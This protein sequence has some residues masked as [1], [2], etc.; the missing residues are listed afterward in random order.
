M[1]NKQHSFD[2]VDEDALI[3]N[4]TSLIAILQLRAELQTHRTAYTFLENGEHPT[5]SL[6]YGELDLQARQ[7]AAQL[8]ALGLQGER[9]ILLYPPDLDY[10]VA[11]FACLYA[12]TIAVPAYPPTNG[13]HM[14]RLQAIIDDSRAAVILS[15]QSV[16][17]AV[18]QFAG[19]GVGLLDKR[20]L[21]TDNL[22]AVDSSGWRLPTLH[23]HDP[24]FLQYTSGSTGN[25]K[26]VMI[27]HGNLMAN[28]RLIKRRF[29]HNSDST[30]VGWLPLYHDMGLIGNVMQPLYCGASAILMSPMAFLEKPV[31]WLQAIS[32]YHAHTSGGPNFA[33]ELCARKITAE[34]KVGLDLGCWQL[35]FNGAE[36]I[37][38]DTLDRFTNAFAA[39]GFSHKAFY[40]CYGL[41]EATL[42]ATGGAKNADPVVAAFN[43]DDLEQGK[44]C[45]AM[46]DDDQVRHLVGCGNID[47]DAAQR[48]R[49]VDPETDES[50]SGGRIG[51]IQLGGPSVSLGYWQNSPATGQAFIGDAGDQDCWLRTGDLGFIEGGELFVSGRLKDLIIIRGRNYYPH[52]LEYAVDAATDAINPGCA[53]AFAVSGDNG[54][55]L[56]VL[57]ELKRNR[58]RQPDYRAEFAAI[59]ARLVEECGMQADTVMLLKPGAILKTSSGKVRRSACRQAFE[60]Q[61]LK[62]VAVDDLNGGGGVEPAQ[63]DTAEPSSSLERTL[64]RQALLSVADVEGARLLAQ[65]LAEKVAVL[66]GLAIEA[67]DMARPLPSLGMDSLKAVELKYF[68]D[69]LLAIDFPVAQL[70]GNH[71]LAACAEQALKLAK[72]GQAQL[73]PV[74]VEDNDEQ[75]LSFGQQALWTV[76]QI[77]KDSPLYNMP[78]AMRIQGKLDKTK[79]QGA[80]ALLFKRHAQLHSGFRLDRHDHRTVGVQLAGLQPQ[81]DCVTCDDE[82]QRDETLSAFMSKPFDLERG[83]LLRAALFSCADEDHV[84][85]F[86][87]HHIIVDFRSL[88]ILLE[89]F[90]AYYLGQVQD[91]PKPAANYA[92][93]VAWQSAY[94]A[95]VQSEQDWQYWQRQLS[96]ELPEL[97]LPTER[98]TAASPS[99]RGRAETLNIGPD[100]LQQLK[101]LAA[102]HHTTLYTLLLTVFKTLLYRYSGQQDIIVGSPTLGRPKREFAN[103]VGY[104]VNP[105]SLRSHPAAEQRF[106]DYLAEV[107]ATVLDALTHQYYPFSLLVEK[108]QPKREQGASAFYR[109]WFALQSGGASDAAELALGMPGIALE[110][111]GLSIESYA[112]EEA[113]AQFDIALLMAETKQGLA[114]SFQYRSD[115]LSR[116]TVLRLIGHFQCLL[117]GML[118]YPDSRLSE[119]PLLTIPE[120]KQLAEWNSTGVDYPSGTIHRDFEAV[121]RQHPQAVALVY[122]EQRLSYAEL[123]TQANRLAQWLRAHGAGPEKRVALCIQRCPEM[124][125]GILAILKAGAVYV[126]VDPAYPKDRQ[127]YLLRD[128]GCKWLLTSTALLPSLDCGDRTTICVDD[129]EAYAGYSSDNPEV[130]LHAGHAAYVIY[131]SGSTGKPKGVVVSHGNLMHSTCARSAYYK[132]P[133]GC[134]L[135]LS[136]F[137]FDSSVAGIFWVLSQGGCLCLPEDDQIKNSVTLGALIECHQVTHLL[138]LPSLYELLLEHVPTVALKTLKTIIVAGETCTNP[139]T[140]LHFNRLPDTALFNEY[141]PTEATVWSSVY[142]ITQPQGEN[143]VPIGK[144]IDNMRMHVVDDALQLLPVGVAGELLVGG[145]GISRGY[146]GQAGLT[147]E[148]FIPDLFGADGG[149]LYRTGDRVRYLV[150]GNIEFLGR[151]DQQVKIRGYRIELGEIETCLLRHPAIK[152][153]AVVVRE[154][155]PGNKRLTAYLVGESGKVSD[156]EDLKAH[157]KDSLPEYML[158]SAWLWLDAMPLN[159]NGKLDRNALPA[160]TNQTDNAP[161]YVAPRDEAEQAVADIWREVLGIQQLS[162]HDDFFELGGHSLSCVQVTA[163]VQ[164]LFN[165]EVPVNILFEAATVAK[166]VDRMAE[167]QVIE[168]LEAI[169]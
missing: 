129:V 75:P 15:T 146:L 50:C 60:Q 67:L 62:V 74:A 12:G 4:A 141:G 25:A 162:I 44:V 71:S 70:L 134:Y 112:L 169:E 24:A 38:P 55:K 86:C 52:D 153:V 8:Q 94:L 19:G 23:D 20:W 18:G 89:E 151:L 83:P 28:Q 6:T 66:S 88:S 147:A 32:D 96:G 42:L 154:D 97:A 78:V 56:V 30:V 48:I 22:V 108:L 101:R 34:E 131:T 13:R 127:A 114:A 121:A 105:V 133:V 26:G 27:S 76:S 144:P 135:L 143:T 33:F 37:N 72:I 21:I 39:C 3:A 49:I 145:D 14:P 103:T 5:K 64:L 87:A 40:P 35:A 124:V 90:K 11:F 160:P 95:D 79:L 111:A 9:A 161:S 118:A 16:A 149:R 47:V 73:V 29:G 165:I 167:Y 43:K 17:N 84:L 130:P 125:V 31:R 63:T 106:S 140:K 166:F 142:A 128:A 51:E 69:E 157:I 126:P 65:C 148:R 68:I 81:L 7:L 150:D 139:L 122:R 107:N 163:K 136:S 45:P 110:W 155:V 109:A 132:E 1:L 164:E 57:A 61:Q 119:L 168:S 159:A 117:H 158:P 91:L 123:N 92:C 58:L 54:E 102:E 156:M 77:E 36:P 41:A 46:A 99:C 152:A 2:G 113:A 10:I 116:A 100:T 120:R 93:Y 138:A 80:L 53:A 59:R 104:F 98:Q 82:Q 115:L 85:A 137:A